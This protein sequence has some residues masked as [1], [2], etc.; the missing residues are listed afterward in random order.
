LKSWHHEHNARFK[1]QMLLGR[2]IEFVFVSLR[3]VVAYSVL[4]T[5]DVYQ[6]G[7]VWISDAWPD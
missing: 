5:V 1:G 3:G 7:A 4:P 2:I 6:A